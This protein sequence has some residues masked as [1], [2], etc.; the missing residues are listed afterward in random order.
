LVPGDDI[1]ATPFSREKVSGLLLS[2]VTGYEEI[3]E[4]G[5]T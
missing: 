5:Q 1:A 4:N 2:T 3:P